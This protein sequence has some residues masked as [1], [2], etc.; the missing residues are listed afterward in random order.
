MS[1]LDQRMLC[2]QPLSGCQRSECQ[3][4]E[5]EQSRLGGRGGVN[6]L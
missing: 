6:S 3:Q 1:Q 5:K 4:L 2:E